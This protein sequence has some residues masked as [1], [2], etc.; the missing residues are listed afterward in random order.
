MKTMYVRRKM[1]NIKENDD[2]LI[3]KMNRPLFWQPSKKQTK[4][5][6]NETRK[7]SR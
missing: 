3:A 6:N 5:K 1:H 7:A 4:R 2:F